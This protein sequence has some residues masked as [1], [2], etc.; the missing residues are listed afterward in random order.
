[1]S[2]PISVECFFAMT[3]AQVTELTGE[4]GTGKTQLCLS[5][6]ASGA[7]LGHRVVYVDTSGGAVQ[8]YSSVDGAQSGFSA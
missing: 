8:V 2:P 6:A 3:L 1:M 7:A 4:A 5:A